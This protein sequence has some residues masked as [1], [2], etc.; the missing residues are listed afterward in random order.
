MRALLPLRLPAISAV[1]MLLTTSVE[2]QSIFRNGFEPP[3]NLPANQAEAARFLTQASFG[4]SASQI[5][6]VQAYGY[7]NWLN[8]QFARPATR[9]RP[10]LEGLS[11]QGVSVGQ[12]VRMDRW[13]HTA[14]YAPD[15]LRQRVAFAFSQILVISDRDDTLSGDWAGTAEYWDILAAHAFGNYRDL[16]RAVSLSPQMGRYLSHLRNRKANPTTG[17]EPDENYAREVM[18]LFSIGLVQRNDDFSPILDPGGEPLPTY[19]QDDIAAMARVFTG[20]TYSGSTNFN[21]GPANYLPMMCFQSQHDDQPKTLFGVFTLT[22]GQCFQDLDEALDILFLHPN[23]PSFISRQLIQRLVTSNPSPEYIARVAQVFK[24]NA[25]GQRG[26]LRA[27]VRAIL[28]DPEAR[29][30]SEDPGYGKPREP[31]LKLTALWRAFNAQA[32][33]SEPSGL[34]QMGIRNPQNDFAQRPLGAPSVFNFY[35]PD[36]QPGGDIADAGLF[37][38]E[39][40][41]VDEGSVVTSANFLYARSW[42]GYLGM[43]NPPANRPLLDI[44]PVAALAGNPQA[45]VDL[46]DVRLTYGSMSPELRDIVVRLVTELNGNPTQK[47]LAAIQVI[48]LSPEFA[49]QR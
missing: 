14:V 32:P 23:T 22:S 16:L 48:T 30:R 8:Q 11:D 1:L 6:Q 27:V 43:N 2:A 35:E 46:L 29:I 20:F 41:I 5:Q 17:T 19:D 34:V 40:Q 28:L 31:L 13:F 33:P 21:S 37:A 38:P 47:A 10:F 49:V 44:S 42:S 9:A 18:Q 24:A 7:I 25:H 45:M 3:F 26:D 39:F 15:Q 4:P 36:F 12:G